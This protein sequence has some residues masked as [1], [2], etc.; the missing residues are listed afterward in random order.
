MNFHIF[1]NYTDSVNTGFGLF[2]ID[3]HF[4]IRSLLGFNYSKERKVFELELF[5]LRITFS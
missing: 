1:M 3:N 5:W 4:T 2:V